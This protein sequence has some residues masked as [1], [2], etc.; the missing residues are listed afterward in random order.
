MKSFTAPLGRK[1]SSKRN[2]RPVGYGAPLSVSPL[3][4]CVPIRALE[5]GSVRRWGPAVC[6]ANWHTVMKFGDD[7]V[8]RPG[9][10]DCVVMHMRVRRL[11]AALQGIVSVVL[12]SAAATSCDGEVAST[13]TDPKP[14]AGNTNDGGVD[15]YPD[16]ASLSCE[17]PLADYTTN[18]HPTVAVDHV[19]LRSQLVPYPGPNDVDAEPE[20]PTLVS[21][22][23]SGCASS[24]DATRCQAAL[25]QARLGHGAGWPGK[26]FDGWGATPSRRFLVF[27]RGD[28]VGVVDTPEALVSFLGTIDTPEEARFVLSTVSPPLECYTAPFKTGWRRDDD[29]AWE[30]VTNVGDCGGAVRLQ[31]KISPAGVVTTVS[32]EEVRPNGACGRRPDGLVATQTDGAAE[33]LAAWLAE[34]AHLEAA[35]VIAFR[36]LE[37][38]L[39]Q[40][41]AP[42]ELR[43]R[44]RRSRADEIRH[45]RDMTLLARRHGREPLP[46]AIQSSPSRTAF[47]I[48]LENAVE[49]CVRETYGALVANYQAR[50]TTDPE[51]RFVMQRIAADEGRHAELAHDVAAWLEPRLETSERAKIAEARDAAIAELRASLERAPADDVVRRAG[52]PGPRDALALLDLLDR[53]VLRVAA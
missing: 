10:G 11:P 18:L 16:D 13:F 1:L 40:L 22:W 23:G 33:S 19:E 29:G 5:V 21:E 17:E 4:D 52:M 35:S 28:E 37:E 43:M 49:G 38:E 50:M 36:R 53:R 34:A 14:N 24:S 44:A 12:A 8:A 39:L 3:P 27:T 51:L 9:H 25:D 41:G 26:W 46:V 31:T 47:A 15:R 48:A 6:H 20:I 45:A 42:R 7:R 2:R 32:R 30:I